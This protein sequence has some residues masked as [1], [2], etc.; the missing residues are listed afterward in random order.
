MKKLSK[1]CED[2][3]LS[4]LTAYRWFKAGKFP[5][6]ITQTDSGTI[7]VDDGEE[8]M[9][10]SDDKVTNLFFMKTIEFVKGNK[11]IEEFAMWV[12]NTFTLGL[13]PEKK[14]EKTKPSAQDIQDHYKKIINKCKTKSLLATDPFSVIRKVSDNTESDEKKVDGVNMGEQPTSTCN[15]DNTKLINDF[16]QSDFSDGN[17]NVKLIENIMNVV[18]SILDKGDLESAFKCNEFSAKMKDLFKPIDI[19]KDVKKEEK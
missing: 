3:G 11:S 18:N 2:N 1:F 9:N 13:K 16:L 14:V 19:I 12:L 4:Y 7:L 6:P 17:L 5:Y 10:G 8:E 15:K